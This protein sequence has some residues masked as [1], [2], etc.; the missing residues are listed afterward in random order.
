[1]TQIPF[2][3]KQ[4]W[5]YSFDFKIMISDHECHAMVG[6]AYWRCQFLIEPTYPTLT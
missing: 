2:Y 1:M 4:S 6:W 3:G 5:S